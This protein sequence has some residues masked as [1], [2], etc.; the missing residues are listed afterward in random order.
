MASESKLT[1]H[2]SMKDGRLYCRHQR[3]TFEVAAGWEETKELYHLYRSDPD[4]L[5]ID[6][7]AVA[8]A[9]MRAII[10][11]LLMIGIPVHVL[12]VND[13]HSDQVAWVHE[14]FR[15]IN[16]G[17]YEDYLSLKPMDLLG[18]AEAE[19]QEASRAA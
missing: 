11:E 10:P 15:K 7:E 8:T 13:A 1:A 16:H 14:A 4:F 5:T 18:R 19:R 3:G 2:F 17:T 12:D 6:A 9:D